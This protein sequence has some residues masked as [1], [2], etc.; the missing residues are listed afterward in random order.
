M[1]YKPAPSIKN[2]WGSRSFGFSLPGRSYHTVSESCPGTCVFWYWTAACL[3]CHLHTCSC[4]ACDEFHCWKGG[5]RCPSRHAGCSGCQVPA[6]GSLCHHAAAVW[7]PHRPFDALLYFLSVSIGSSLLSFSVKSKKSNHHT[8]KLRR[9]LS[10]EFG[11]Q[12]NPLPHWTVQISVG[13]PAHVNRAWGVECVC[14]NPVSPRLY[15]RHI[16]A[17]ILHN[18]GVFSGQQLSFPFWFVS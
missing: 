5:A 2:K 8:F 7:A 16:Y 4:A 11:V 18:G 12:N 10:L 6:E 13:G 1:N 14:S 3:L 17:H 15:V 9:K